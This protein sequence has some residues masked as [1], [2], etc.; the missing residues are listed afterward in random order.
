MASTN[1]QHWLNEKDDK[2]KIIIS[3]R[4][5]GKRYKIQ[6]PL[7]DS[8][9]MTLGSEYS[10]PFDTGALSDKWAK[11]F[12]IG[13]IGQKAGLRMKKM[14]TNAEPTEI[15]FDM[16][17]VAYY[18]AADEVL[19]PIVQLCRLTLGHVLQ[20]EDINK[21]FEDLVNKLTFA[22]TANILSDIESAGDTVSENED[23]NK[24]GSRVLEI[25]SLIDSPP[26]VKLQFG[27]IM[28]WKNMYITSI[29]PQFSNVL[30]ENGIPLSAKV[31][32]TLTPEQYPVVDDMLDVFGQA[33]RRYNG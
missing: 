19:L 6:S 21:K 17:F 33:G 23:V 32:V 31:S 26:K 4:D 13:G 11:A 28:K 27:N 22:S 25:A 5:A 24:Y 29:A 3:G 16:E 20:G 10:E 15:S 2:F 7:P 1:K 12:A 30:D 8:F 9:G 18:D 14:F